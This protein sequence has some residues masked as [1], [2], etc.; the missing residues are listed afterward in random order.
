MLNAVYRLVEPRK[1]ETEFTDIDLT[2]DKVIIR[3]THLSIC[4]ADQRYY[5]GKRAPEVLK[6]KLPMALI[7]EGIGYV[8]HDPEGE[9]KE[10]EYVV[11]IPNTPVEKDDIIAE[12]YLRSSKFRASG[13][14]GFMQDNVAM[15]RDRIVRLPKN[16][17]KEVAAFTEIASVSY[18]A[19]SRFQRFSHE[20][21]NHIGVWGDGNLG[22]ITALF[23]KYRMPDTKLSIFGID[24]DKMS[25]FTFADATYHVDEIPEDLRVD[26]AFEC[27]GNAA[28]GVAINQIID[29]YINPE[30]TISILGVSENPVPI[31]TRMVLEKGLRI[32]GSSRS[33][34]KDFEEIL[35]FYDKNPEVVNYLDY[36]VGEVIDVRDIRDFTKAF[37]AD[38]HKA[39]GK[40]IMVWNK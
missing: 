19:I 9:F 18:H 7:H 26:H 16:I 38:I 37:E 29:N 31:D 3:P 23:I 10:G 40:T 5:Q 32:F 13:F 22:F 4:N 30:G 24:N 15:G 27:I 17:K 28:S 2:D 35:D 25:N 14:D 20:R 39:G 34:R 36:L 8:V 21:R 1:F 6:K 12:N 11:M 33:G